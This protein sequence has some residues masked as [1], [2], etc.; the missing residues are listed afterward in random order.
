MVSLHK[1]CAWMTCI[2]VSCSLVAEAQQPQAQSPQQQA[3]AQ[4]PQARS[5]QQQGQAPQPQAQNQ[6]PQVVATV[7]GDPITQ[8]EV[9]NRVQRQLQQLQAEN[10]Q[11]I[12]PE[13]VQQI[14]PQAI[15]GLVESRLVEQY[16]IEQG[17][18]VN[19]QEVEAS[20]DRLKGQLSEQGSTFQQFL[21]SQGHTAESFQNRIKGSIAWHK[22]QQEQ[23]TDE[24]LQQF[25]Q[26]HQDRFNAES[27]D[28]VRQQVT[29]AY[30]EGVWN[31]IVA[32]MKPEAEIQMANRQSG[33]SP[34]G[35][36]QSR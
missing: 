19:G 31:Q 26:Q 13:I 24:N 3:Q 35:V 25:F 12:S 1:L 8:Q 23:M 5:P 30:L 7:N 28:H 36:P 29:N 20:V 15:E 11:Q 22:F 2:I 21:A 6:T 34:F 32:E 17:P 14:M 33:Q 18:T 16:A 10:P 27:L 4:Q 9:N